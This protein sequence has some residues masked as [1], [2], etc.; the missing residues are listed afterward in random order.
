M[1]F[2]PKDPLETITLSFDFTKDLS[3]PVTGEITKTIVPGSAVLSVAMARGVDV[4]PN[5]IKNGA[6]QISGTKVLQSCHGGIDEND[7][8]W[9]AEI[10]ANSGEHFV[11][12]WI[13]PVRKR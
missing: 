1:K 2:S 8:E 9:R 4:N 10:D 6:L 3:D 12:H 11:F 5:G 13:L 7:Y